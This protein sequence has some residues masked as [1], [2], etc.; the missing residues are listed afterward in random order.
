MEELGRHLVQRYTAPA[1]RTWIFEH[2][3][4][5]MTIDKFCADGQSTPAF[6]SYD[7][8]FAYFDACE[9]G[10]HAAD[11]GLQLGGPTTHSSVVAGSKKDPVGPFLDHCDTG[12]NAITNKSGTRLDFI[13]IHRKGSDKNVPGGG[14]SSAILAAE[15]GF[16]D[17]IRG[18]HPTLA[19]LP[20]YNDEGDPISGWQKEESF[21]A[22]A[23]Y[24]AF[25][26]AAI[27]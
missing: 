19:T 2:W 22:E 5:P 8:M 6:G 27:A 16:F 17:L 15:K 24:P 26:G 13:S 23:I 3:N 20:F 9:A 1:V 21:R 12:T 11:A 25:M 10:L 7:S 4:E 14:N 18:Q